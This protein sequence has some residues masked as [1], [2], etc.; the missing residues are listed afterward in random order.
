MTRL[1]IRPLPR[2]AAQR[3]IAPAARSASLTSPIVSS[4]KWNTLAASTAS[5]PAATAGAK[6]ADRA[7]A[8]AGDHRHVDRRAHRRDQLEVVAVLG[9]VGVHRVQQDLA[10]AQ[11]GRRAAPTRP[12]RCRCRAG[13]RAW[14]PRTRTRCAAPSAQRRASDRQHQHLAAEPVGD[15]AR[16]AP[17]GRSRRC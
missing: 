12:R 9:A 16:S 3:T 8:A 13:R 2:P 5:A 10:R 11:L 17:A 14:S 1:S 15:L 6:C 4:P 7:G